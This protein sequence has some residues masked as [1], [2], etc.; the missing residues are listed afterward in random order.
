MCR[1]DVVVLVC[2]SSETVVASQY[3]HLLSSILVAHAI[4]IRG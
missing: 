4:A 2:C 3:K 1:Q